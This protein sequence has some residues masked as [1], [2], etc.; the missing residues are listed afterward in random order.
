MKDYVTGQGIAAWV[1]LVIVGLLAF[2]GAGISPAFAATLS[3]GVDIS[4][5]L[6]AMWS[7]MS[8]ALRTSGL[9]K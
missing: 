3:R 4:V 1:G 7:M 2:V 8:K 6:S 9:P 5:A